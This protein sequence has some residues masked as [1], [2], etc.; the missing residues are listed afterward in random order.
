MLFPIYMSLQIYPYIVLFPKYY[1]IFQNSKGS[2]DAEHAPFLGLY[3]VYAILA[4]ISLHSRLPEV[5]GYKLRNDHETL[6]THFLDGL[7]SEV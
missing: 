4:R 7:S 1:Q 6:T 5:I 3:R 2:Y